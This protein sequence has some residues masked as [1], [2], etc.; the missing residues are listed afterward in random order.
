MAMLGYG[1]L[2]NVWRL[3]QLSGYREEKN[4]PGIGD[5]EKEG[6]CSSRSLGVWE[7]RGYGVKQDWVDQSG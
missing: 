1:V 4:F 5:R 2:R 3:T 6:D 7:G